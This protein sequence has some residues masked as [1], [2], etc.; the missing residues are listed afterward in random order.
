MT[1]QAVHPAVSQLRQAL[2]TV[3]KG[4][5]DP[6][7][8]AWSELEPAVARLLGGPFQPDADEHRAMAMLL[9]ATFGE[10]VRRDL[11]GFWFP[12]R[13]MLDGAAIGFPGALVMFSPLEIVLQALSRGHLQML[14]DVTK[15][16][17]TTVTRAMVEGRAGAFGPDDYRRMF[18]P[19]FVQ[20]AC[21]D[22]A[23]VRGALGRSAGDAAREID[24][25]LTR[26]PAAMPSEVRA[27]L[28]DQIVGTLRRMPDGPLAGHVGQAL[29]LV[30]LVAYLTGASEVTRF[31]PAEMWEHLL[32]PLMHIGAAETFPPLED[33]DR[34]ALR[35]GTDPL[36]IYV[37]TV[38]FATPA[39]DEDGVLGVFP[40]EELGALDACFA[41]MP[42]ARVATAPVGPLV[43]VARAFDRAAVTASLGRFTRHAVEQAQ[44][45]GAAAPNVESRLL[46]IALELVAELARVVAA[47]DEGSASSGGERALVIRRAPEAEA[48]SDSA[49]QEVRRAM[50]GSR[51]ILI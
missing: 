43:G 41:N 9:A 46:P 8:A 5:L 16:L 48:Q 15:D 40:P 47:V 50:H 27:S 1:D 31:A 29:P 22:L 32:L 18:D 12:N 4:E 28:R 30:E 36:V 45:T 7:S 51:I 33:D 21:V 13:S 26:L 44:G 17:G 42:A 23:K 37:E 19:G 3:E 49:L 39:V 10:R 35:E 11:S 24:E 2:A 20:L 25:A 38:P 14:D 6:M 34:T